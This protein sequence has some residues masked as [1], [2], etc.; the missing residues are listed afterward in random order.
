MISRGWDALAAGRELRRRN[1]GRAHGC[2]VGLRV[3][4]A[5]R[6]PGERQRRPPLASAHREVLLRSPRVPPSPTGR[7]PRS[8]RAAFRWSSGRLRRLQPGIRLAAFAVAV[9]ARGLSGTREG[10]VAASGGRSGAGM[11][12]VVVAGGRG[13]GGGGFAATARGSRD[14]GGGKSG[15]TLRLFA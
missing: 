15:G 7:H 5:P 11:G 2:S 14:R 1:F 12:G 9:A 4:R 13:L 6:R 3:H 10:G 8:P